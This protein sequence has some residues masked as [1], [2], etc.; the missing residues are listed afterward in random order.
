MDITKEAS[1][2]LAQEF[3]FCQLGN[4]VRS[5]TIVKTR[6]RR[7]A[8]AEACL[9]CWDDQMLRYLQTHRCSYFRLDNLIFALD[10][11]R[12]YEMGEDFNDW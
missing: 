2:S 11:H 10:L 3:L 1:S 8:L 7:V 5:K 6:S 12:Y 4:V 9:R